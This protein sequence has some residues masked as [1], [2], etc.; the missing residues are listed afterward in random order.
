[1]HDGILQNCKIFQIFTF[2]INDPMSFLA[3]LFFAALLVLLGLQ[4]LW[5]DDVT[6]MI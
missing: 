3:L 6:T 4:R 1:L 2:N 5:L